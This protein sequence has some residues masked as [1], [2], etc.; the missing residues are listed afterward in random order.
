MAASFAARVCGGALALVSL[1]TFGL[2]GPAAASSVDPNGCPC[3]LWSADTVPAVVDFD[4]PQAVEVGVRF[5]VDVASPITG[6]R[7]YKSASN[8]GP[9]IGSL[10]RASDGALL[11]RATFTNETTSGWQQV[12]FATPVPADAGVLY[13]A[14]YHTTTGHYSVDDA[15]FAAGGRDNGILH[16]PGGS[17]EGP[18]GVFAY[19]PEP[20][21]PPNVFEA[22]NYWVDVVVGPTVTLSG[23]TITGAPASLA[24]GLTR[25]LGATG[26]LSD[27]TTADLTAKVQWASSNPAVATVSAT[28][29]LKATGVGPATI[30]ASLDGVTASAAVTV[31]APVVTSLSVTPSPVIL[32]LL[33]TQQLKAT[34]VYTD[35]TTVDVTNR[36]R[37]STSNVLVSLTSSLLLPGRIVGLLPGTATVTAAADGFTGSATVTVR[38]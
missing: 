7:F 37:W 29:A 36:A 1:A 24:K 11:A 8:T 16:A 9:H 12:S 21:M 23:L 33:G 17:L 31:T 38:L 34:L 15:Y 2:A 13:V 28:G 18:N 35:G 25:Q 30:T 20:A 5:T 19:T 4:D 32:R 3:S 26:A 6:I 27:N 14:S 22:N 10:W